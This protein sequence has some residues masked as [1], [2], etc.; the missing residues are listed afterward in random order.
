LEKSARLVRRLYGIA[1]GYDRGFDAQLEE[2]L[3]LGRQIFDLEIGIVARIDGDRY[4]VVAAVH[5][6]GVQLD[7]GDIFSLQQTY[8]SRTLEADG[9]VGFESVGDSEMASHPAYKEQRLEAYVGTPLRVGDSVYGTLNFSSPERRKRKF[10]EVE[11][12]CLQLM[13]TW[14]G[15][16]LARREFEHQLRDANEQLERLATQDPLTGIL[17]RRSVLQRLGDERNRA[18]REDRSL[19]IFLM[20]L[21][22]FKNINDV[23]G[24]Q[25]GDRVLVEAVKRVSACLRSYDHLGRFGGEEFLAI[26]PG[27]SL[28]QAAEIA[29]RARIALGDTPFLGKQGEIVVS[30]SFGVSST[31]DP[32]V[33][34]DDLLATADKALYLAKQRGRNQ[35]RGAVPGFVPSESMTG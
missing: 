34:N 4:Q 7:R 24:H 1:T 26:L 6:D 31:D 33:S 12:D 35:I 18:A 30:G 20:D 21:D 14:L 3:E 13:A 15:A 10:G 11:F 17:N 32:A 9:P 2:L 27:A 22:R 19:G 25:T 29:E 28:A 23:H 5:P 16:E 8:C